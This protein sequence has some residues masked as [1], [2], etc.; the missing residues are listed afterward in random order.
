MAKKGSGTTKGRKGLT[1]AQ[2]RR[3]R[4]VSAIGRYN[5]K[6]DKGARLSRS[7]FW[8]V[9]REVNEGYPNTTEAVKAVRLG[10]FSLSGKG[11]APKSKKRKGVRPQRGW[12][13]APTGIYGSFYWYDIDKADDRGV[14]IPIQNASVKLVTGQVVD[15]GK[16]GGFFEDDDVIILRISGYCPSV[17]DF[18]FLYK[19]V[20]GIYP[21][22][23]AKVANS[24]AYERCE[25]VN[26]QIDSTPP[27]FSINQKQSIPSMG[28]WVFDLGGGFDDD[29][30][31][32][33]PIEVAPEVQDELEEAKKE[34]EEQ[35]KKAEELQKRL[36][37]LEKKEKEREAKE[38]RDKAKARRA[39]KGRR[40]RTRKKRK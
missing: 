31:V 6:Q 17:P 10:K 38:A 18:V 16:V 30:E 24:A 12:E 11:T 21:I 8:K 25:E 5:K 35:R 14:L 36:D 3:S 32:E 37:R 29:V 1:T 26:N 39:G 15:W 23:R 13:N 2:K 40:K 7:E 27:V 4:I 9:Y 20:V 19:D 33:M 34:A 22:Y 28:I